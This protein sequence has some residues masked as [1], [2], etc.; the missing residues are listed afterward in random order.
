MP[1]IPYEEYYR[2]LMAAIEARLKP[3]GFS[4]K[5]VNFY[6]GR[7]GNLAV[8]N[9]W[10]HPKNSP[11]TSRFTVEILS[12][13]DPDVLANE[14]STLVTEVAVPTLLPL[15]TSDRKLAKAFGRTDGVF[16]QKYYQTIL[17]KTVGDVAN[18][19]A[20]EKAVA[21]AAR[22]PQSRGY[23]KEK[24]DRLRRWET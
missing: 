13:T 5:G 12:N 23:W 11:S 6:L 24:Y 21:R 14:V 17:F 4:R 20:G 2:A 9:V 15:L 22:D 3:L 10:K 19:K 18:Y 8:V 16:P 7:N 1:Q